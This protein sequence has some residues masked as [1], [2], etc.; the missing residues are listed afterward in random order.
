MT[1]SKL[2]PVLNAQEYMCKLTKQ[3]SATRFNGTTPDEFNTWKTECL[4]TLWPR[5][6]AGGLRRETPGVPEMETLGTEDWHGLKRTELR[7]HNA[8]YD[9]VVP[10]TILQPPS[11]KANGAGI[12]CQ[13]GHGDFG[14]LPLLGDRG[15]PEKV[16]EL[17][18]YDY[19]FGLQIA[20][21]GYTVI[22]FDL[23][24]FGERALPR[25]PGR[26]AC[27]LLGLWTSLFGL[28]MVS[29]M[30]SDVRH[31]LSILAQWDGV[32]GDRL[33]MTGLSQ[34]GRITMYTTALDERIKVSIVSGSSN[35]YR[36]RI[37]ARAGICG[38]QIVP[39]I[40]PDIDTPDIFATITP[41]PLQVQRGLTDGVLNQKAAA[42]GIAHLE[43]CY[44]AAGVPNNFMA[45]VF[46]G[47]HL[48]RSGPA[49][50]WFDKWL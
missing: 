6:T 32:D 11:G 3:T 43:K 34:G 33:G 23:I 19:D 46:D 36:D 28:N 30:V 40:L 48:Y 45:H 29:L 27:D 20:K 14:R 44:A 41:R 15:T 17:E 42:A 12:L 37:E 35:T 50:E 8:D 10:A 26:D 39:N 2:G 49:I 38:V 21:A 4:A 5:M 22:A 31:A 25:Q 24:N 16:A 13:H 7:F 47:G 9:L 1:E 18:R